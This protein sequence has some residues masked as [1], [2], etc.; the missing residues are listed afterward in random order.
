MRNVNLVLNPNQIFGY[1][2]EITVHSFNA[3]L[4]VCKTKNPEAIAAGFF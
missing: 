3:S 4:G 1:L 2:L